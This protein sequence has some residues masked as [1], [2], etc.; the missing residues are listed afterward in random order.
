MDNSYTIINNNILYVGFN[1]NSSC[2]CIGTDKGFSIYKS[3]PLTDY[4]TREL[5]GGIGI[6]SMFENS[7]ILAL[8]GGGK[9]PFS[10][11]NKLI[12]WND[13]TSKI[14]CEIIEDFRIINVKVKNSLIAIIGKK[15]TK[16]YYFESLKRILNYKN[17]DTIETPSNKNGLLGLNLNP[18]IHIIS[19]LSRNIGEI[20][21]KIYNEIKK[22]KEIN[23]KIKTIKAHHSE[24][25]Y[26]S[27]NYNGDLLAS[28][29]EKG[30]IIR[31][32]SIK[33][34]KEILLKELRR[35]TDYAE[36]YC[37]NFD[38][39]SQYLIC[40]SNKGTIHIFNVRENDGVKN[41]KSY[42]SS[43]GSYLNIQNDYLKNE[44][45]FAQYHIDFKGKNISSFINE[46]NTFV[47]VTY[48]GMYYRA[49][50]VPSKGGECGTIQK[51]DYLEIYDDDFLIY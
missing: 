26:M 18:K 5:D 11:L 40:G 21:V 22:D 50:F 48:S 43:I 14:I 39:N 2:F 41:P 47:V 34:E 32:F 36:I 17:I 1:Q 49:N 19:Y 27:L 23:S 3:S 7:N 9:H 33:K 16:I 15:K 28:C 45:S 4:Y 46:D 31:L 44:W 29:S 24:I 20:I 35:G 6:I 13:A 10:D 42:F 37:L 30:T 38:K 25:T 12:I 8:V 51:K